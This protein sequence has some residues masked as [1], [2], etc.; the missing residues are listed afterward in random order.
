MIRVMRDETAPAKRRDEMAKAAAPYV[1]PRL[2]AIEHA[3]TISSKP[4][5]QMTDEELMAIIR[6][7]QAKDA[8]EKSPSG[9]TT[10]MSV[11]PSQTGTSPPKELVSNLS[12]IPFN[13]T[14]SG[15]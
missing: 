5:D 1:H 15:A 14:E 6:E 2:A 9:S 13:L 10:T 8:G 11:T 3:A 12:I 7:G 4:P